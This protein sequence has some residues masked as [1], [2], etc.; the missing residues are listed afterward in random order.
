[1]L[2]AEIHDFLTE[3]LALVTVVNVT[4]KT[5]EHRCQLVERYQLSVY[6]AFIVTAA[7]DAG[8]DVLMTEDMQSGQVIGDSLTLVNP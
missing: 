4:L 8:C 6:D 7:I 5:H 3:I 2:W 1:M